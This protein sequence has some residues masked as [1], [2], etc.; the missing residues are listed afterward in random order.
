MSHVEKGIQDAAAR[1]TAGAEQALQQAVQP[2]EARLRKI[3]GQEYEPLMT[4]VAQSTRP[5]KGNVGDLKN[6]VKLDPDGGTLI[7]VT[8]RERHPELHYA[9]LEAI[10]YGGA[11][12]QVLFSGGVPGLANAYDEIP[13]HKMQ[14]DFNAFTDGDFEH[15]CSTDQMA[16]NTGHQ[17]RALVPLVKVNGFRRVVMPTPN[18]H[19]ARLALTFGWAFKEA[20]V[21]NVQFIFFGLGNW[22]DQIPSRRLTRGEEAFGPKQ[23]GLD[24]NL[25]SKASGGEYGE[26]LYDEC[27]PGKNQ[28]FSC[29]AL[30][31]SVMLKY[32]EECRQ[33]LKSQRIAALEKELK[34]LKAT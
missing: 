31:P 18:Q 14:V 27:D 9:V 21:Q 11:K 19:I 26:R 8:E 28:G 12:V 24:A 32:L 23:T 10:R 5:W 2:H 33:N 7:F 25:P 3:W 13:A 16:G 22:D 1:A 34:T 30:W 17:A 4:L 6:A 29:P 15:L 20:G